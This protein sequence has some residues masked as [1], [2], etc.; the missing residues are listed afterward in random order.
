MSEALAVRD[1]ESP[2]E[3]L[4]KS[5]VPPLTSRR[6]A[7]RP[8][9]LHEA[10]ASVGGRKPRGSRERAPVQVKCEPEDNDRVAN[11][12]LPSDFSISSQARIA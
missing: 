9:P 6:R 3:W 10:E 1:L 12:Q 2:I 8:F 11:Q 5:V 4:Q 7:A